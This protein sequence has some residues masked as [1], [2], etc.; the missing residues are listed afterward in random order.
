MCS[1]IQERLL[2]WNVIKR[3][4]ELCE[5][6]NNLEPLTYKTSQYI[7]RKKYIVLQSSFHGYLHGYAVVDTTDGNIYGTYKY[8]IPA[9]SKIIGNINDDLGVLAQKLLELE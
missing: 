6:W 1:V 7:L 8:D 5:K 9:K 4:Q 3:I 2:R